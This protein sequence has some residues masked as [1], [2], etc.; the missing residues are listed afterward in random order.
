VAI[1]VVL[2]TNVVFEGLTKQSSASG[3]VIDAWRTGLITVCI[4]NTTLNEYYDV[5]GRKLSISRFAEAIKVLDELLDGSTQ[6][7]KVYF[8][9]RPA[10]PDP[11][12]DHII[13]C[14]MNRN[15]ILITSNLRDFR[16]A[17]KQLGLQIM[18]SIDLLTLLAA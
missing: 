12:D 10:S 7:V 2:D 15:A 1:R 6:S 9:W 13:D 17:E 3:L 8:S 14:A 4:T 11:G 5:L 16:S 18:S